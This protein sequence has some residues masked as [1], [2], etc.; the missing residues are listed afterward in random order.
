MFGKV[1]WTHLHLSPLLQYLFELHSQSASSKIKLLK[2]Q[3]FICSEHRMLPLKE[4][5]GQLSLGSTCNN[6]YLLQSRKSA[7]SLQFSN[8][9]PLCG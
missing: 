7:G 9:A 2:I 6:K 4:S 3:S 5:T 8:S 1:L